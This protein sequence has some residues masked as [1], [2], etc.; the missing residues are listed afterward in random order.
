MFNKYFKTLLVTMP[1]Q[2]IRQPNIS[3]GIL[4]SVLKNAGYQSDILYANLEFANLIGD[5]VNRFFQKGFPY[6]GD[7]LFSE[8]LGETKRD[9]TKSDSYKYFTE[10]E[11]NA[12]NEARK[13]IDSFIDSLAKRIIAKKYDA[14][15]FS[16]TFQIVP[17]LILA[18]R[19]KEHLP[20]IP[21]VFGGANCIGEQGLALHQNFKYIDYVCRGEGEEL[22]VE[23]IHYLAGKAVNPENIKGL[24]WRKNGQS[25]TNGERTSVISNLDEVPIPDYTEWWQQIKNQGLCSDLSEL[26]LSIECSRGCWYGYT[27]NCIFCGLRGEDL[28]PRVKSPDKVLAEI[29]ELLT[30]YPIRGFT[31]VDLIFPNNFYNEFLP[32][33]AK[34]ELGIVLNYE[35]K[36]NV[37]KKQLYLFR[38]A[39]I[40]NIQ[41]G[42]ESLSS[43]VLKTMRKG[44][45]S[46]VNIRL[47]KWGFGLGL[48][49]IWHFIY[50]VPGEEKSEYAKLAKLIGEISHLPPPVL[51]CTPVILMKNSPL[52]RE[53]EE[54]GL[55]NVKPV[56]TY[57]DIYDIPDEE[58]AKIAYYFKYG[59]EDADKHDYATPIKDAI[60]W[61]YRQIGESKFFSLKTDKEIY[62]H[63]TRSVAIKERHVLS[64]LE[65]RIYEICDS[66]MSIN[67]I[68]QQLTISEEVALPILNKMID[69]KLVIY[70][71][72]KYLSL[73]V[74]MDE[75]VNNLEDVDAGITL[76]SHIYSLW[77]K[78]KCNPY[79]GFKKK[80][81]EA[82]N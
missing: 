27:K 75:L 68:C 8:L 10:W 74:A 1:F 7:F 49:V 72:D 24:I 14:V 82:F 12:L 57:Y 69:D 76:C 35:I 13:H 3:L 29:K 78:S 53:H 21:I 67:V 40:I 52:H 28:K 64:G 45:K 79:L 81:L 38:D 62:F 19:I 18:K 46:F 15:G 34:E 50:G 31:A 25:I 39:G 59:E 43:S 66:G 65:K 9:L 58:I 61:W 63:D 77:M 44:L 60:S 16:L 47:L 5:D 71:D 20:E 30:K 48:N 51:G 56:G 55:T 54:L 26:A 73:A 37:S 11:K 23:L 22:I 2:D 70:I 4:K 41:P 42:I 6:I 80:A 32:K 36:A 33:L 17:S